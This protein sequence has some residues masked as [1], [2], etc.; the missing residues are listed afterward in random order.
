[1]AKER[2]DGVSSSRGQLLVLINWQITYDDAT[3]LVTLLDKKIR[4]G[5]LPTAAG[6]ELKLKTEL[7]DLIASNTASCTEAYCDANQ[8]AEGYA[9]TYRIIGHTDLH[10][11]PLKGVQGSQ[12]AEMRAIR[13][14]LNILGEKRA[15][16]KLTKPIV[17]YSDSRS[18]IDQ[19]NGLAKMRHKQHNQLYLDIL[20]MV[21][22]LKPGGLSLRWVPRKTVNLKLRLTG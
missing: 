7:E 2:L 18:T 5:K 15:C 17:V 16:G 11:V 9:I 14:L 3:T 19:L 4:A 22:V 6:Q 13:L 21:E 8:F 10:R 20:K 12:E 1:V